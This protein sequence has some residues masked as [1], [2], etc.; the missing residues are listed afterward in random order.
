[1]IGFWTSCDVTKS[2]CYTQ[3][4]NTA[5]LH[6]CKLKMKTVQGE[7]GGTM[8][9]TSLSIINIC[10]T[11]RGNISNRNDSCFPFLICVSRVFIF[12]LNVWKLNT[13]PESSH[14]AA[15]YTDATFGLI[16][17][18]FQTPTPAWKQSAAALFPAGTQHSLG[19]VLR[20]WTWAQL[21]REWSSSNEA[22]SSPRLMFSNSRPEA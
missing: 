1:M 22:L 15:D 7:S 2:T 14:R 9:R 4:F 10:S 8:S 6:V 17:C 16:T 5:G 20:S 19:D 13:K 11:Q 3:M 12:I 21:Q 18:L